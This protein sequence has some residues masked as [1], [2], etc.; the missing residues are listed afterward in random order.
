[1]SE[2]LIGRCSECGGDVVKRSED[3]LIEARAFVTAEALRARCLD[4]GATEA[5]PDV[6]VQMRR[7]PQQEQVR[8]QLRELQERLEKTRPSVDLIAKE[9]FLLPSQPAC[10]VCGRPGCLVYHGPMHV[11]DYGQYTGIG[12]PFT[13]G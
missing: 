2:K 7:V 8:N 6:V 4:C 3:D 1:M 12:A 5:P 9:R 13:A 11:I 10:G